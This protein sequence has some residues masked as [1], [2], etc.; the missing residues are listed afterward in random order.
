MAKI[1]LLSL[2][3]NSNYGWV[4]QCYALFFVLK[5]L[6]HD[7]TYIDKVYFRKRKR[8]EALKIFIYNV[9]RIFFFKRKQKCIIIDF[10]KRHITVRTSE[11]RSIKGLNKL[12][13]FDAVIV[14][15]DQVWRPQYVYPIENYYLDFVKTETCK[16]ISYAA[17]FGTDEAEYSIDEIRKCGNLLKLFNA[18]SVRESSAIS[19]IRDVYKWQS[20]P[21]IHVLDPTLLLRQTDYDKLIE[22]VEPIDFNGNLL[23]YLLDINSEK[24]SIIRALESNLLEKSYLIQFDS[25]QIHSV[26]HWLKAFRDAHFV[27]T[28]SYHGCIFSIIFNKPFIVIGNRSRGL[29]R[30]TSL[31]EMFGLENLMIESLR[32]LTPER[33]NECLS[34]DWLEIEKR[35]DKYRIISIDFLKNAL[36]NC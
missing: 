8:K 1:G 29:A 33:I 14:G 35:V 7:V 2:H 19:L 26:E 36:E 21:P 34:I 24:D 31:L 25:T 5:K 11:I 30:F 15:S 13:H 22:Q 6:G 12:Q 18:V 27:L 4:L 17:S 23:C 10:F 3:K 32:D 20:V 28:D 16:K 9:I